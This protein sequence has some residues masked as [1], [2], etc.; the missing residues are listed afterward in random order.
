M[1]LDRHGSQAGKAFWGPQSRLGGDQN[2]AL[3]SLEDQPSKS[4]SKPMESKDRTHGAG[5]RETE[6]MRGEQG[7]H[8]LWEGG[9]Q[10]PLSPQINSQKHSVFVLEKT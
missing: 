10:H 7:S 3:L 6:G 8:K 1:T 5:I 4:L 9:P 2:Q